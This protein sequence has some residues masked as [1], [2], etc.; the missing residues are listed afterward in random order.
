MG[1]YTTIE[2]DVSDRTSKICLMAKS[3]AKRHIL[4]ET[5]VPTTRAGFTNYLKDKDPGSMLV[6]FESGAHKGGKSPSDFY[7]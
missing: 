3:G 5:T 1:C 4:E 6:T 2:I 7:Y